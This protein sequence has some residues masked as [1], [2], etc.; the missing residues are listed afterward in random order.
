MK[1]TMQGVPEHFDDSMIGNVY[2]AK[3]GTLTKFWVIVKTRGNRAVVLGLDAN[4][5]ITTGETYGLWVFDGSTPL[6]NRSLVGKIRGL[7]NLKLE[8]DW[9]E[10]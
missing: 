6:F 8:V 5:E 3:G 7:E 1:V 9:I 4:G 2:R 10:P